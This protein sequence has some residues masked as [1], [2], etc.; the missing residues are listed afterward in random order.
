MTAGLAAEPG[1][2]L[3]AWLQPMSA[4]ALAVEFEVDWRTSE[5]WKAGQLPGFRHFA[6]MVDRWGAAFVEHVFAP[7]L[8]ADRDVALDRRLERAMAELATLRADLHDLDA[9][10]GRGDRA[11][12][13]TPAGAGGRG[14]D[15]PGTAPDAKS[16]TVDAPRQGPRAR[17]ALA[18]VMTGLALLMALNFTDDLRVPRPP[19]PARPPIA[20]TVR[21]GPRRLSASAGLVE[22]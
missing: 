9:P 12:A 18:V 17:R 10:V 3:A 11:V 14:E 2:R 5:R 21:T 6:A 8:L 4:K 15:P 13:G 1:E 20:R 19:R 22:V 7:A 16:A